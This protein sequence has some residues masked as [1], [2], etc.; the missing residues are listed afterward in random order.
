MI[1]IKKIGVVGLGYVGLP[2]ALQFCSNGYKV[3]A[4][5]ND[6]SKIKELKKGNSYLSNLNSILIKKFI[7]NKTLFPTSNFNNL[8]KV[9]AIIL[10]LPT[11]LNIKLE[12]E[13]KYINNTFRIVKKHIKKNLFICLES[14]SYPGTTYETIIS[15]IPK[16]FKI[17]EDVFICYSPE[18]ND[19]GLKKIKLNNIPKIVSGYTE[20]CKVEV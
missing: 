11:P 12:P 18:R 10:C 17:G 20:K 15:K 5:D 9:D 1:N 4:F 13:L 14:T 19:P 2:R 3:F 6:L 8:K 16:K 7:K